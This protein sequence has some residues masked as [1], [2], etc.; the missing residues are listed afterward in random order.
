MANGIQ[1]VFD[2]KDHNAMAAFWSEA[3]ATSF[4][5][6]LRG[7]DRGPSSCAASGGRRRTSTARVLLSIL[8]SAARRAL[9]PEGSRGQGREELGPS[10]DVN[11]AADLPPEEHG[12]RIRAEAARLAALGAVELYE[13]HETAGHWITM[14]DPEGN[15]FCLQ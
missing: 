2:C 8:T 6:L 5:L 1:V 14:Q 10:L 12:V 7:S 13:R 9:L 11:V 3:S 15:E 4:S